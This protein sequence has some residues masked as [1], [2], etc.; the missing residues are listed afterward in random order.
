MRS[1]AKICKVYSK[2]KIRLSIIVQFS[3]LTNVVQ[4]ASIKAKINV[5]VKG[6]LLITWIYSHFAFSWNCRSH[7]SIL[8]SEFWLSLSFLSSFYYV[9]WL[10]KCHF[11]DLFQRLYFLSISVDVHLTADQNQGNPQYSPRKTTCFVLMITSL[12]LL[13]GELF[14]KYFFA[15]QPVV[16]VAS[17][18]VLIVCEVNAEARALSLHS[19]Q[20]TEA[21]P[22]SCMSPILFWTLL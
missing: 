1:D 3:G 8:C 2:N 7:W 22:R 5:R 16:C 13:R 15:M 20:K 21:S 17:V 10:D 14:P 12:E 19:K 4:L 9:S 11:L 18:A 6:L